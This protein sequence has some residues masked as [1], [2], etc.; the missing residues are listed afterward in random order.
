MT[1][2]AQGPG[3]RRHFV[4]SQEI[5]HYSLLRTLCEAL[6]LAPFGAAVSAS[7]IA[8][9]WLSPDSALHP[10]TWGGVKSLYRP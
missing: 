8:D 3:V 10:T 1:P 5:D 2:A 9:V 4:S 6:G 7:S